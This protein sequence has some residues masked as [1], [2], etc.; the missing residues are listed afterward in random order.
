MRSNHRTERLAAEAVERAADDLGVD[1]E[2]LAEWLHSDNRLAHMLYLAGR[3]HEIPL[4]Q[5][6]AEVAATL[7]DFVE[8]LEDQ[9]R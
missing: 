5:Y 9:M 6:R 8:F 1:A 7:G 3:G 4:A 2:E